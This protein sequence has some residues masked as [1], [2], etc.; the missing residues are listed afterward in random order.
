MQECWDG[1][2]LVKGPLYSRMF[3]EHKETPYVT[4]A[5]PGLPSTCGLLIIDSLVV[6]HLQI[7][8]S[9]SLRVLV[10]E[11]FGLNGSQFV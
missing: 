10:R 1:Q 6:T 7:Y 3:L 5:K 11:S 4:G 8:L 2:K 9:F